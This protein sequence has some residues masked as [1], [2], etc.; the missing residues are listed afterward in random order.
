MKY[1]GKSGARYVMVLG[2]AELEEGEAQVRSLIDR[3]R[4]QQTFSI[5]DTGALEAF[6]LAQTE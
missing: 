6:F 2:D 5:H 3:D 4:E 1:A